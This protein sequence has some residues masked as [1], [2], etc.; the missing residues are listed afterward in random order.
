MGQ[1]LR[2]FRWWSRHSFGDG[3]V[4]ALAVSGS[5]VYAAGDFSAIGDA[6]GDGVD[7]LGLAGQSESPAGGSVA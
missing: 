4:R 2:P 7:A 6:M 1:S 3:A 5:T